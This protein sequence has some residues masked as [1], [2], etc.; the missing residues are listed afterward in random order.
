MT[1][2]LAW[3]PVLTHAPCWALPAAA[4]GGGSRS[5]PGGG[6]DSLWG[7]GRGDLCSHSQRRTGSPEETKA[8][9]KHLLST[10]RRD[11]PASGRT[12]TRTRTHRSQTEAA[13]AASAEL[14]LT[15]AAGEVKTTPPRQAEDALAAWTLWGRERHRNIK[16]I[17]SRT[18][19]QRP[20]AGPA[21]TDAAVAP[22]PGADRVRLPLLLPHAELLAGDA[23]V[24]RSPLQEDRGGF[25]SRVRVRVRVTV[26]TIS[27]VT[28]R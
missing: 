27:C 18:A 26:P 5:S 15:L 12:R 8:V 17:K 24:L 23:L 28:Y 6:R 1:S 10:G 21:R 4:G 13:A 20:P 3:R 25:R 22:Q 2:L 19:A 11:V 7:G 9:P 14:M 16:N